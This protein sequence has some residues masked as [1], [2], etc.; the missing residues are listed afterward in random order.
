MALY[1]TDRILSGIFSKVLPSTLLW[2][3]DTSEHKIYLTFDDGPIPG[4][5]YEI[6]EILKSYGARATFFCVGENVIRYP[7][8]KRKIVEEGHSIGNHT[9]HHLKGWQTS[10]RQYLEDVFVASKF[11]ESKLFRPPYGMISLRQARA[12]SQHYQVVMW[13]VLTRD[14]DLRVSPEKCLEIAI[15]GIEPGAIIVFHDNLK[16]SEKVLYALPRLLEYITKEG[17]SAERL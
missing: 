1:F 16:A 9:H 14:Y 10:H 3:V 5:T 11:I 4:L 12:L 7:E 15:Q 13:S 2:K 17:Y 8:I 6:L